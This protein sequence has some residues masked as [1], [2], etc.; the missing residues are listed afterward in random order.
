MFYFWAYFGLIFFFTTVAGFFFPVT[1]LCTIPSWTAW[2]LT[3]RTSFIGF[4][5]G[6]VIF[7]SFSPNQTLPGACIVCTRSLTVLSTMSKVLRPTP[8]LLISSSLGNSPS[9]RSICTASSPFFFR[10]SAACCS[11]FLYHGN[12]SIYRTIPVF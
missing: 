11:Y 10:Y 7:Y 8:N 2:V 1:Y 9:R 6:Y 4:L 3:T 5:F 12:L